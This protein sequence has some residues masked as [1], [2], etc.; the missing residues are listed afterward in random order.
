MSNHVWGLCRVGGK[1]LREPIHMLGGTA[2]AP[3]WREGAG[4]TLVQ[5]TMG[6]A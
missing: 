2:A 3:V 5:L 4:K 1:L 6:L